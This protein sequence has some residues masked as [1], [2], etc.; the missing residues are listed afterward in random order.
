MSN[1]NARKVGTWVNIFKKDEWSEKNLL[2][3]GKYS[4]KK[5]NVVIWRYQSN[6]IPTKNYLRTSFLLIFMKGLTFQRKKRSLKVRVR[7]N[8]ELKGK[9]R[10]N[11][12]KIAY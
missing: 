1:S 7:R 10:A 6:M 2:H 11:K 5:M 9:E 4:S 8:K 12:K 3:K